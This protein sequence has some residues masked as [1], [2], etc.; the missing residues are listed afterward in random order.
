MMGRAGR[1]R[2]AALGAGDDDTGGD[3]D[4]RALRRPRSA[5]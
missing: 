3:T 4:A 2:L 5:T 1:A